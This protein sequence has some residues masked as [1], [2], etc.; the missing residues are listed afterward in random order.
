MD[1]ENNNL[2]SK[3]NTMN[4]RFKKYVDIL[5]YK[6]LFSIL[7]SIFATW[8]CLKY[9]LV[10]DLDL[11]LIS[12]A[13]VFPLVFTIGS[14][15][16][17]REKALEHLGR[18]KGALAAIKY[19]FSF[20]KKID[21]TEKKKMYNVV[22]NVKV[23]LIKF[24][25]SNTSDDKTQLV[26]AIS[27]IENFITYHKLSMETGLSLKV[28]KLMRD[29]IMGVENSISIKL[30]RTPE[31]IRAYCELFIYVFPFFYAPSLIKSIV[32]RDIPVPGDDLFYSQYVSFLDNHFV[33]IVYGLNITLSF[34]L[35]TLFNVQ[36]QIENPYD[37]NGMDDIKLEG[38]KMD[39]LVEVK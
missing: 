22:N 11:A 32:F 9:K 23:E 8:I 14:A 4:Y 2:H 13:V 21:D 12:V 20:S 29:V 5:N 36:A 16:K 3:K 30:H 6:T 19:C 24:L 15:F 27:K 25:Y 18:A 37:Q 7:V 34:F 38:Y 33:W 17:R 28:Y 35:I 31:S 26:I 1:A 10:F 39:Y